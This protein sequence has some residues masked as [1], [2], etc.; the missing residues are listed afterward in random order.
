M[1]GR[2]VELEL[3]V[4]L[5]RPLEAT[6]T[7]GRQLCEEKC[8]PDK[9]L[10]MPMTASGAVMAFMRFRHRLLSSVV[11]TYLLCRRVFVVGGYVCTRR[12]SCREWS[13]IGL[14]LPLATVI[15]RT[16]LTCKFKLSTCTPGTNVVLL[17]Y[18]TIGTVRR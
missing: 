12:L 8:T 1:S 18:G 13:S 9:I 3:V 10:A 16:Q 7:K 17:T 15:F 5:D 11:V 4:V 14:V 2:F 6:T